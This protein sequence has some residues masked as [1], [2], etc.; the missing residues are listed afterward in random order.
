[1]FITEKVLGDK[2]IANDN[3][4]IGLHPNGA[5]IS[6]VA[7]DNIAERKE[8]DVSTPTTVIHGGGVGIIQSP[9]DD[10]LSESANDNN[11][12]CPDLKIPDNTTFNKVLVGD[13]LSKLKELPTSSVD[14]IV[15]SPPYWGLRDYDVA[16]QLGLEPTFAEYLEKLTVIF[17]ECRRVLKD[18]GTLWINLGDKY[19]NKQLLGMPWKVAF[20]LQD[21]GWVLRQD[22]IWS[23]PNAMPESVTDRCTK[24]HE[25]I[26]MFAKTAKNYSY[27]NT[28]IEEKK[29]GRATLS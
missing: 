22:I 8:P 29:S 28:T 12:T 1:M 21:D 6:D 17:R 11:P 3:K 25:Y 16:G 9:N 4:P 14:C 23:K 13:C 7:N 5:G 19:L 27:D 24:S 10:S 18:T 26:F 15:T 2:Y 20:A